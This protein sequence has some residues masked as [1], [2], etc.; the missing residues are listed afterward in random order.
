MTWLR[1]EGNYSPEDR[2]PVAYSA[3]I[4]K[5]IVV[6]TGVRHVLRFHGV[7]DADLGVYVC[8]A[9]NALGQAEASIEMSGIQRVRNHDQIEA[10]FAAR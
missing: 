6:S 4:E 9:E 5:L 7:R 3:R 8:R 10:Q 2:Q 1:S